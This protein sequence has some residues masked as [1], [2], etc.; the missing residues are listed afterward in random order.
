MDIR[1]NGPQIAVFMDFENVATSAE[2]NFG[3]F[4]VTA[5][6]DLL[7]TRGRLLIK[8]AYGDWGRFHR[9]RRAMLENGVDLFQL[10]SVG[11]QQK[12]R[13]DVRLAID[14]LETVFT[15]PSIDLYAVISGDSDFTELIHKLRDHGKYTI[16]IGLR[17]ATS[18]LLRRACD[19]FIFYETLVI[20]EAVDISDELRLPDPRELLRRA[21]SAAEQKGELPIFAGRLKQIILNLD[22]SF[23][24]ANYGYQQF[25]AFLEAHP[26][27]VALE[28][29]GLQLFVSTPKVAPP[30][31]VAPPPL[32]KPTAEPAAQR[33]P[34]SNALATPVV[35]TPALA[36][37]LGVTS[38]APTLPAAPIRPQTD[39][40]QR[41]RSFLREAG[42]RIVDFGTRQR[43][44]ADFLATL[45]GRTEPLSL[46][47]C[48]DLL[49]DRYDAENALT[50]KLAV[51]EIVR[52]L[53]MSEALNFAGGHASSD[54]PIRPADLP[55]V[56]R[57]VTACDRVYI[58]R[59]AEGGVPIDAGQLAPVMYDADMG[60]ERVAALCKA[61]VEEGKIVAQG[62][63]YTLAP[64]QITQLLQRPALALPAGNLARIAPP[65]GEPV[66]PHTA[67]ALFREGSELRQK[68]FAGSAQRYLQAA[69]VQLDALRLPQARAG[70]DDL[71]WYLAS[72]CS[73]KAG[74]AF[75]TGNYA[76][77]VPYYLA[78][79]GLAQEADSVWP[80]IQRLVN[81]MASYF[82]AIAGKELDEPVPPNLGRSL[83]YQVALRIHNHSNGQVAAAWEDLMRR[84]AEVNLGMIRQTHREI[85]SQAGPVAQVGSENL[86]RIERTRTFLASLIAQREQIGA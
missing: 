57:L 51:P 63:S 86:A 85:T 73:V 42:L 52:L 28:E 70:F 60:A 78:F 67:E 12:N 43:V 48:A 23:S 27:L 11:M 17:S 84:L 74:H 66:T 33:P 47:D 54:A 50:Q 75:V 38:P 4:D 29:Q 55:G 32:A 41:Y 44:A 65:P 34:A 25:R 62:D 5:V 1:P 83:A 77:A 61:L 6:M 22:S 69:R 15:R 72:Y 20:E 46:N 19:E 8:R 18:D 56:E 13:A 31:P 37:P 36:L 2:A 21:L 7:R 80:R 49:K 24:E 9:Y 71:K 82:Y 26:D 14:A 16:G 40:G 68:D 53:I 64:A 39:L 3:D 81:P 59:L 79:F 58:L 45:Q 35:A 30:Q 76:E 10:Y